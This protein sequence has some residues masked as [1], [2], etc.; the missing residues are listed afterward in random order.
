MKIY[1]TKEKFFEDI[2]VV[3]ENFNIQDY[4]CCFLGTEKAKYIMRDEGIDY[5][6]SEKYAKDNNLLK[7]KKKKDD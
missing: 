6:I 7:G 4:W 3:W 1:E 2:G 5:Y